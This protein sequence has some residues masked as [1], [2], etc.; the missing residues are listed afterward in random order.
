MKRYLSNFKLSLDFVRDCIYQCLNGSE[1]GESKWNRDDTSALLTEYFLKMARQKQWRVFSNYKVYRKIRLATKNNKERLYFI[2]DY[3]AECLYEEI[4]QRNIKLKPIHYEDR[5]DDMVKKVRRIGIS[6]M[7][8]QFY[9]YIAVFALRGM[10]N[11]KIGHYQCA[12]LPKKGQ[13]FGKNAIETWI[14]TNPEKCQWIFKCDIKK[15]YP[16]LPHHVVK[17]LLNRDIKNKD[18][19]YLSYTLIDTYESGLCIGSFFCQYLANYTLSYAYHY[20]SEMLYTERR[21]KRHNL[22]H[23]VLFY[24]D[25]IILL[26]SNKKHVRRAA[27]M[28]ESYLNNF[29]ELSLKP[30]YQLFPLDSRP[31]DMMGYQIYTYKTIVR[32]RIFKRANKVFIKMKNPKNEMTLAMAHKVASYYGY[33]KHTNSR[34]YMKKVK[35]NKTVRKAKEVISNESKKNNAKLQ[36]QTT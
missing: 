13:L 10:F 4:R 14:R 31:I 11:A 23:H 30:D 21:G 26:G 6:S 19:L 5:Y 34:K 32:E 9:D 17:R 28:L 3:I 25:D 7:K 8:Q 16:S 24:M 29:L 33:F 18:I 2:V 22:V 35:M 36:R 15:F 12:S 20:V 27:N 1:V